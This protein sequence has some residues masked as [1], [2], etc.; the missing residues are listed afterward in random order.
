MTHR[1]FLLAFALLGAGILLWA[2][3]GN[4]GSQTPAEF[5]PTS[6]SIPAGES[7]EPI[8]QGS[9]L[10]PTPVEAGTRSDRGGSLGVGEAPRFTIYGRVETIEGRP[11][12]AAS[13]KLE[14]NGALSATTD[15]AGHF[16]L[17][18]LTGGRH[19]LDWKAG[20]LAAVPA[21]PIQI[22]GRDIE[23]VVLLMEDA[24]ALEGTVKDGSGGPLAGARISAVLRST[25]SAARLEVSGLERATW[26][27]WTDGEGRFRLT[28]LPRGRVE[29]RAEH[30]GFNRFGRVVSTAGATLDV[31]LQ[32]VSGVYGQVV[33]AA[34]GTALV[35]SRVT[36][37]V[38][39]RDAEGPWKVMDDPSGSADGP[40]EEIGEFRL[41]PRTR[42]PL[43]VVVEGPDFVRVT[44]DVLSLD[45]TTDA[46][47]LTF[48]GEDGPRLRGFVRDSAGRGIAE[49][50][51]T[52]V[53]PNGPG[54]LVQTGVPLQAV[55]VQSDADGRFETAPVREGP[56]GLRVEVQG[57]VTQEITL[58]PDQREL[59]I[60]LHRGASIRVT[61]EGDARLWSDAVIRTTSLAG[62][63]APPPCP[64][65]NRVHTI[66]GLVPGP[67]AVELVPRG[68]NGRLSALPL[69]RLEVSV[70]PGETADLVFALPGTGRMGGVVRIDG[71]PTPLCEVL[72]DSHGGG[73]AT[74]CTT[75]AEGRFDF[76]GLPAGR[77]SVAART[78]VAL[79]PLG[80]QKFEL[81]PEEAL[82]RDI[83][84]RTGALAGMVVDFEGELPLAGVRVRLARAG[85]ERT[86]LGELVT[87]RDGVWQ[88][89]ELPLGPVLVTADARFRA[90]PTVEC[91][92]TAG[93]DLAPVIALRPAGR[94]QLQIRG[95]S[96]AARSELEVVVR[97]ANAEEIIARGTRTGPGS[98][99]IGW[100]PTGLYDV[101]I[102]TL[103]SAERRPRTVSVRA[104]HMETLV[105]DL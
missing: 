23:G 84:I 29:L 94:L 75:D 5:D 91:T 95:S 63:S 92:N 13:V 27:T 10:E 22:A 59:E 21:A 64:S 33:L 105:L 98:L 16:S 48:R 87:D 34:D 57:F 35:V 1:R 38:P 20:G 103:D 56:L 26:T 46:G 77:Y 42:R 2:L 66:Q 67:Y 97:E 9:P 19:S 96:A 81:A 54:E 32:R 86:L 69:E 37:V 88:H 100:L 93:D 68:S 40:W 70:G 61:L 74:R 78:D 45:G 102:R 101:E 31:V 43:R 71:T 8:G 49:T 7:P 12:A 39:T 41:H 104:G 55:P 65:R 52:V 17:A 15:A 24:L 73:L 47:P 28:P 60:T 18:G 72:L 11:V 85:D 36:V 82:E 51:L 90:G 99:D 83:E 44:S 4:E 58:D 25:L 30:D 50:F 76:R 89:D 53:E 80:R 79:E 3:R 6:P 62:E 14:G